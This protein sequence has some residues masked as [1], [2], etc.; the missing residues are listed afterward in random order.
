MQPER[1][2]KEPASERA[3]QCVLYQILIAAKIWFPY[4]VDYM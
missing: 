4:G 2:A 3:R 1:G